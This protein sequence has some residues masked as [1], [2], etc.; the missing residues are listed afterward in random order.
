MFAVSS[1]IEAISISSMCERNEKAVGGEVEFWR[2]FSI[3][4]NVAHN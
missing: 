3:M 1:S 2:I 4:N